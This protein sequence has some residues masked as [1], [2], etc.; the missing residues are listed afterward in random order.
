MPGRWLAFFLGF[1]VV[2]AHLATP[3]AGYA[4]APRDYVFLTHSATANEFWT[5]VRRGIV[6]ACDQIEARCRFETL[7]THADAAEQAE[8]VRAAVAEGVDGIATTL[9]D[10]AL[11]APVAEALD[12]GIPVVAYNVDDAEGAA[13]N[14]RLAFIGQ[15]LEA[16]GR[17]LAETVLD[18]VADRC[19]KHVLLGVSAPG[20]AW[21]ERRIAGMEAAL[22]EYRAS[23]PDCPITWERIDSGWDVA[24]TG[25]RVADYIAAH[26]ETDVYLD[27]GFWVAGAAV[28][29]RRAGLEPGA[30]ALGGFD[31]AP[32][33]LAEIASGYIQ[34]TIDQQPYLQGYLAAIQLDLIA[35][36]D[37]D[38]WDVDTG[39]AVI[40][41]KDLPVLEPLARQGI[42]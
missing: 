25:G 16:S 13:G 28:A 41:Q 30:V 42:R 17:I 15:D 26:P 14:R 36:Y 23:H 33:V 40:T 19:P 3:A 22:A 35:R 5:I 4:Q 32:I 27:A 39:S 21:A 11:D 6:D 8:R 1:V 7:E 9:I 37:L 38:G 12:A 31:L 10:D 2:L 20:A 18:S 24:V 34:A 29:L